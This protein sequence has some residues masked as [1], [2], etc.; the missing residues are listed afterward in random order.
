MIAH[1]SLKQIFQGKAD[2]QRQVTQIVSH[3]H[4]LQVCSLDGNSKHNCTKTQT[5]LLLIARISLKQIFPG[6]TDI[7]RQF[8]YFFE[9]QDKN[10]VCSLD[11]DFKLN[12]TMKQTQLQVIGCISPQQI[13]KVILTLRDISVKSSLPR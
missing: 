12:W 1:I 8:G 13:F 9:N 2:I 11:I 4:K 6:K 7:Q 5:Q 3:Q 10:Q